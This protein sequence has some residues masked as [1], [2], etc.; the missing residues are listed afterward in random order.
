MN[1]SRSNS[2]REAEKEARGWESQSKEIEMRV[3]LLGSLGTN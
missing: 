2:D 1:V 3:W